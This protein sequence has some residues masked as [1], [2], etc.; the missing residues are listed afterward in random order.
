MSPSALGLI[1]RIFFGIHRSSPFCDLLLLY[2][3]FGL[4]LC[5]KLAKKLSAMF[6]RYAGFV[7][8]SPEHPQVIRPGNARQSHH[9][10]RQ[11]PQRPHLTALASDRILFYAVHI[12]KH[13][14]II[15]GAVPGHDK[16]RRLRV[17]VPQPLF[18]QSPQ[19]FPPSAPKDD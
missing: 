18:V 7:A 16:I 11:L 9:R 5:R 10:R 4:C 1:I 19:K 17:P 13:Q 6:S 15:I 2:S 12:R 14:P 3:I 8:V